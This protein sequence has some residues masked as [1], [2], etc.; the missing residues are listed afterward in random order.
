MEGR[1]LKHLLHFVRRLDPLGTAAVAL[2]ATALTLYLGVVVPL[3][4]R[5]ERLAHQPRNPPPRVESAA[6]AQVASFYRF[7]ERRETADVWLAKLY[8]I[9]SAAGLDWRT[10]DYRLADA[11][12]GFERY[13]IT[14]PV[15]GTYAQVRTFAQTALAEVP[16]ASLD[17][18]TFRRKDPSEARVEAEITLTLYLMRP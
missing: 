14:L 13:H 4:E 1:A 9:A 17:Q 2:L 3:H 5:M 6:H 16:V 10:G 7:F 8:G 11:R 12:H 18:L 15:T